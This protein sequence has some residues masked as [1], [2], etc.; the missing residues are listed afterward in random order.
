[1]I[2]PGKDVYRQVAQLHADNIRQGFLSSLG[3]PFLTLLYEAIDTND[4]SVLFIVW[5]EGN[6]IGFVA[7]AESV[8]SIYRQ[9][10][11]CWPKLLLTLLPV[12]LS[13]RKLWKI[14]EILFL[15][16]KEQSLPNLPSAE[17]LSIA[18]TQ[19]QRSSGH[20]QSLYSQ[21]VNYFHKRGVDRFRIVVGQTLTAAQRFYLKMG[22]YPVGCIQVHKGRISLVYV[23]NCTPII[24]ES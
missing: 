2:K 19:N 10:L 13:P 20:A 17:L 5:H 12:F 7:G 15:D 8:G 23:H 22:A 1:M 21:L 11:R 4:N 24:A 16:R 3:V 6:V 18:I 14:L 9:L